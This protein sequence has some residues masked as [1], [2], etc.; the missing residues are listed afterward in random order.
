MKWFGQIFLFVFAGV[1]TGLCVAWVSTLYETSGERVSGVNVAEAA[2]AIVKECGEKSFR[3]V[4]YEESV[5][6]LL[7]DITSAEA[8]DLIREIRRLDPEYLYCHVLAHEIGEYEVTQDP[9]NWLDGL[10]RGPVDGLCSN[11][12][13][14]GAILARF[15]DEYFDADELE[16]V[17]PD[18]AIA[19]EPREGFNPTS[20][21]KGMCYHGMGHVLAHITNAEIERALKACDAVAIKENSNYG[22]VCDEGVYMQLFQPLEPEDFSLIELLPYEPTSENIEQFCTEF[23]YSEDNFATCWREAWPFFRDQFTTGDGVERYCSALPQNEQATCLRTVFTINGRLHL[24]DNEKMGGVCNSASFEN[25]AMC[26]SVGANAYLE[27]SDTLVSEALR[28]CEYANDPSVVD[29]CMGYLANISSYNYHRSSAAFT[30]L[31]SS[32]PT[33]WQATCLQ[34]R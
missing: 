34:E 18:L 19:C 3:P 29:D 10:A 1:L 31:C 24:G 9:D 28:F 16:Q 11:G 20:L 25:Q 17:I 5:P 7:G 13:A 23:S 4:C 33:H 32:V 21:N 30:E 2:A 15:N 26:F 27:E 6:E 14:H 12:Y 8:F 22:N